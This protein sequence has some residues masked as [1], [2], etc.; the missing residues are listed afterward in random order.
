[1]TK[2]FPEAKCTVCDGMLVPPVLAQPFTPVAGADYVCMNCGRAYRWV[3]NP[4][5]L[6]ALVV[7]APGPGEDSDDD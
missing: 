5:R 4:P 6:T 1:M 2:L 3:G 7:A